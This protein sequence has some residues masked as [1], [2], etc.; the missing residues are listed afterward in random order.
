MQ[1]RLVGYVRN[2]G[3]AI[4]EITVEGKSTDLKKFLKDLRTKKPPL[5]RI[6]KLDITYA[7]DK[8]QPN[9]FMIHKSSLDTDS[10]G[11]IIPPDIALCDECLAELRDPQNRRFNYFFTTC[12]NCGPRFTTIECLPYDRPNTAM[13]AFPMCNFCIK[14]FR[15]PSNR[16][17][18]AQTV[19][20][21]MC[22][23]TPLLAHSDGSPMTVEDPIRE[24]G[25]LLENGYIVA[26]K[27]NGG[28]HLATATTT[29]KP[30]QRLRES[31]H[32]TKKPFAV[33]ARSLDSA[34]TF[35]EVNAAEAEL[36]T[37]YIRPIVLLKKKAKFNLSE[38]IAPGL[39]NIGVML[40]YTGTHHILF[41]DVRE[42][43]FIMTSANP[44]SEPIVAENKLAVK[45]LGSIVDYFLFHDRTIANRC[46]DSV[47]RFHDMSELLI[48][49]SRGYAPE[50]ICLKKPRDKC[51]LGVG[52]ESNVT[53]CIL[54]PDKAFLSQHIGDIENLETAEFHRKS[55][56]HLITLTNSRIELITCDLHPTF[57]TTKLA[58]DFADELECPVVP[59][60][61]HH[62]HIA[63]LMGESGIREMVGIACDGFGYGADGSP[64]GGEILHCHQEGFK[65][66]GHLQEQ[67][68]VG[69]DLATK[70]PLRMAAG[71]LYTVV[72]IE[73][74]LEPKSQMLSHGRTEVTVI[75]GQLARK[76][77]TKTSSCGR[78]LDAVAAILGV[79]YERTYEGEPAMKL[80]SAAI[81]GSD[82]LNLAPRVMGHTLDTTFLAQEIF[83]QREDQSIADLACSA[84]S[85]LARGLAQMAIENA[86][87]LGITTIG[88]SG[89]VAYNE[90]FSRTIRESVTDHGFRF[91]IHTQVPPG[92]GGIAF[93]QTIA[94]SLIAK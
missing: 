77:K 38:L 27:G 68:M 17:F 85:Y 60:Q 26:I 13:H 7:E 56:D 21:P 8:N 39:H 54:Q 47:V 19:A 78:V 89:G 90:H 66:L 75:A 53:S 45:K 82:T 63:S 14:E 37:S 93:G 67:P 59:V 70:Y 61:H 25:R 30:I 83:R 22:G 87:Q 86:E 29:S 81:K 41:D 35:A 50:P 12:T 62:A 42:P 32:R 5:A 91:M 72:D 71:M 76:A 57:T 49:R 69:G 58:Q 92:D 74:W 23:P 65:R 4:V 24:T 6:Y 88:L 10:S 2:R 64:W 33:M 18:H 44:P 3:D 28:F 79:C 55:I 36:L 84:E 40:P 51:V 11:S 46:D 94:A 15:D 20:C 31:K 43:A 1:N 16:R 48:R 73:K 9:R 34:R 52:A 80:E